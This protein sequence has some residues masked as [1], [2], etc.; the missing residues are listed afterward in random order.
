M[1]KIKLLLSLIFLCSFLNA[2]IYDGVV[3]DTGTKTAERNLSGLFGVAETADTPSTYR[4]TVDG[5]DGSVNSEIL[6][7]PILKGG[8]DASD[9]LTLQSTSNATKGK[10]FLGANS[11]YDEVN[12][13]L[14]I[15]IVSPVFAIEVEGDII[16]RNGVLQ[17]QKEGVSATAK[18]TVWS[19]TIT[20]SAIFRFVR[21]LG[22]EASPL[23][24]TTG[25][26][27]GSFQYLG[28]YDASSISRQAEIDVQAAEDWD[29]SNKGTK[30]IL[31]GT[32]NG[33]TTRQDW[34][35][36]ENG[37][38]DFEQGGIKFN[39]FL[40]YGSP[41]ELTI[42]GGVVT[43]VKSYHTV[44]TQNDDATD[45]LDTINGGS[46]G[47]I[48]ILTAVS[49]ARVTTIKHGTGNISLSQGNDFA[50]DSI[51]STIQLLFNG[52]NWVEIT[53]S[54]NL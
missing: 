53:R 40:D 15:G 28:Y 35:V 42:S 44:D 30:T 17:F 9:N 24:V 13:R 4:V 38:A 51:T 32:R 10:I 25:T 21:G 20:Q 1:K 16:A 18:G 27:L 7:S 19:N 5:S 31:R 2:G 26:V 23:P 6:K 37:N 33:S 48:L 41:T 45:E 54:A 8:I 46:V 29:A 12:D 39:G 47:R 34:L 52:V 50:L 36:L 11:V 49:A 14:G 3:I 43:A 22:T